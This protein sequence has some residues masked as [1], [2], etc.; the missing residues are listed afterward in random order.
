MLFLN[1]PLSA[2]VLLSVMGGIVVLQQ[3]VAVVG[4]RL[5]AQRTEEATFGNR[6]F[7]VFFDLP[8][9]R[10]RWMDLR[11]YGQYPLMREKKER[12]NPFAPERTLTVFSGVS[13]V[14][15]MPLPNLPVHCFPD[16]CM[17]LPV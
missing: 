3:R 6:L 13:R 1:N 14:S 12:E 7:N 2:L 11:L 8:R 5:Y 4:N 9:E 16:W 15:E 17:S 10:K